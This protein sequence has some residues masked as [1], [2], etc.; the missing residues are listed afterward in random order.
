VNPRDR[1]RLAR[2]IDGL[3]DNPRPA[4]SRALQGVESLLRLRVGDYRIVYDITGE[5][6]GEAEPPPPPETSEPAET[7]V[8]SEVEEPTPTVRIIRIGH[9]RDV[10][11]KP[12]P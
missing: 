10:Y 11:R 1:E 12:L 4:G 9:R 5:P 7:S 6:V 3:A 8:T 2:A